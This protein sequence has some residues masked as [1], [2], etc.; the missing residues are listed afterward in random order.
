VWTRKSLSEIAAQDRRARFGPVPAILCALL[1]GALTFLADIGGGWYYAPWRPTLSAFRALP[2]AA[3]VSVMAFI[4]VYIAQLVFGGWWLRPDYQARFCPRC[5]NVQPKGSGTH[6]ACGEQ[7]ELLRNWKW[8]TD[9][10]SA[11]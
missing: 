1:I 3:I 10:V 4:I 11:S 7:L 5:R 6:C 9:E 2:H 8:V